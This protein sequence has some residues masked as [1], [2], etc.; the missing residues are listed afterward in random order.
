MKRVYRDD[1]HAFLFSPLFP[2]QIQIIIVFLQKFKDYIIMETINIQLQV[3]NTGK[4]S[5]DEFIAK[6]KEYAEK[7]SDTLTTPVKSYRETYMTRKEQEAY[8]AESLN[9]A[10]DQMEAHEKNG[11][12]PMTFDEFLDKL[13]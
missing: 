11:T 7:L 8:V 2:L 13:D 5:L 9:R 4:Y 12:R 6:V 3:P 10:L 1:K